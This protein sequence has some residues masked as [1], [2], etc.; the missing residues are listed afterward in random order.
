MCTA[1]RTDRL[2]LELI[3]LKNSGNRKSS[4]NLGTS[5]SRAPLQKTT[6]QKVAK[7]HFDHIAL[8]QRR[9]DNAP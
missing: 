1:N 2:R 3:V 4:Q 7:C 6:F 5:L 8:S 9:L